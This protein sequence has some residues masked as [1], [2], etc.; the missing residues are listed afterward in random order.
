MA[1]LTMGH[2]PVLRLAAAVLGALLLVLA[3]PR[4]L[5]AGPYDV[6]GL[7]VQATDKDAP[8]TACIGELMAALES[9]R[10][11]AARQ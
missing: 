7:A 6:D 10:A 8:E 1:N 4:A 9:L 11:S 3:A 2:G 5:L